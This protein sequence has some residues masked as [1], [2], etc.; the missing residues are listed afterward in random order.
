MITIKINIVHTIWTCPISNIATEAHGNQGQI[1][2]AEPT[3]V[4]RMPENHIIF[5][6]AMN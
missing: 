4:L 5:L 6:T 2:R 3:N 1:G